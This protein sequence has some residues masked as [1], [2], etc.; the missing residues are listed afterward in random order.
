MDTMLSINLIV[1]NPKV[2]GGRPC[3]VD[4]GVRVSDMV[5]AML[6]HGQNLDE[7]QF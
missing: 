4:T 3:I 7:A 2:R 6:F 5:L 1:S